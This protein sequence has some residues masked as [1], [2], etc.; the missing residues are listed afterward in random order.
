MSRWHRMSALLFGFALLTGCASAAPPAS[1]PLTVA[2]LRLLRGQAVESVLAP[3]A[4]PRAELLGQ[5]MIVERPVADLAM[6][7]CRFR[8]DQTP[9]DGHGREWS[10]K[11]GWVG[12]E[13]FAFA[14]PVADQALEQIKQRTREVCPEQEDPTRGVP[15]LLRELTVPVPAGVSKSYG[16][17]FEWSVTGFQP[18]CRILFA[19]NGPRS[20]MV[21]SVMLTRFPDLDRTATE[22]ARKLAERLTSATLP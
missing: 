11:T 22:L 19:R 8:L 3:D 9:L 7:A 10:L 5:Q 21:S 18:I 4:L 20:G 12:S 6:P 2:E 17:C 16:Y 15:R 1:G 14:E 13:A